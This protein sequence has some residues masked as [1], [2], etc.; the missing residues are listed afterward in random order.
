M[1]ALRNEGIFTPPSLR[2]TLAMPSNIGGA[3]W[4]GLAY[5]ATRGLAIVPV[6]TIAA[7]VRL[8]P[9]SADIDSLRRE[10]SRLGHQV[11]RLRGTPYHQVRGLLI[12]ADGVPC[13]PPPFGKLVAVDISSRKIAWEV[14]LGSPT[15]DAAPIRGTP[16]W[17]MQTPG[18]PMLGGPIVTA[19]GLVFIAATLDRRIRA[20]DVESGHELWSAPL[21]A[22]G[23]ATPMTYMG[24][25]GRQ[26]VVIAAGGDGGR[27]GKGDALVAFALPVR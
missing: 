23:K 22:G 9:N 3:H 1:S 15:P 21:P 20:F 24:A 27:F 17:G 13:S 4:G 18:S 7:F 12:G 16:A 8:V 19:G 2:G 26:Y 5:D 11:N 25:D 6:N 10:A 14:P